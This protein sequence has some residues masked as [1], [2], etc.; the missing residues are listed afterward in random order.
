MTF[1]SIDIWPFVAGNCE[2]FW[3]NMYDF[4]ISLP[5]VY[6]KVCL[7]LL[8]VTFDIW[9][10]ISGNW[11]I[12]CMTQISPYWVLPTRLVQ[13][14]SESKDFY[15]V[16]FPKGYWK[17]YNLNCFYFTMPTTCSWDEFGCTPL[18]LTEFFFLNFRCKI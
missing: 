4:N 9:P 10:F 15:V 13:Y 11:D 1:L 7:I 12:K 6:L 17:N 3:Y 5:N 2:Q 14:K 8:I 18:S 16:D